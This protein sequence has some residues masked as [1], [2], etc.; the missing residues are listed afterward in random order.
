MNKESEVF[1]FAIFRKPRSDEKLRKEAE[2]LFV[3][4]RHLHAFVKFDDVRFGKPP[5][6]PDFVLEYRDKDIGAELTGLIP[7]P[8]DKRGFVQR[9]QFK[10]WKA[11]F[12]PNESRQEFDWGTYS[13][14]ESLAAF[15]E[16]LQGKRQKAKRW[17]TSFPERWLLMRVDGG[18]PFAEVVGGIRHDAPG[19]ENEVADYIAKAVYGLHSCCQEINPF[20][21]VI[22]FTVE[23]F[24]AFSANRIN[25]HKFPRLRDEIAKRGEQASDGFLDWTKTIST[26]KEPFVVGKNM[27]ALSLRET[28]HTRS[29]A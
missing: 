7:K 18:S 2:D 10:S 11:E 21:Y 25:Q 4:L 1:D 23:C 17:E 12:E 20:D 28:A 24:L 29:R 16:Q 27:S 9:G 19:R 8:F 22:L 13:L 15:K 14:S 26:V 3:L 5:D 6:E